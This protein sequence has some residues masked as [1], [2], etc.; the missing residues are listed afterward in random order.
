MKYFILILSLVSLSC[1][2]QK[3]KISDNTKTDK[4]TETDKTSVLNTEEQAF[5]ELVLPSGKKV[6]SINQPEEWWASQLDDNAYY[7][8]RKK[9]TE[10]AFTGRYWDYKQDG[11][12]A[13]S[14]CGMPLFDAKTKYKSGTG[15]PSYYQPI[16]EEY[17]REDTD[18]DLG[19]PRTEV[20]CNRCGGHLGHVFNDGPKPT[21]LRY[22]INSISLQFVERD[23]S[24]QYM[25]DYK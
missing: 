19:Y 16:E 21:G 12:Y 17:I 20:M 5:F 8:L 4:P 6:A 3:S 15:W 24:E 13:C 7:V 9:G 14:A 25:L 11:L 1:T 23:S 10:R 2:A 18:Y 22:C